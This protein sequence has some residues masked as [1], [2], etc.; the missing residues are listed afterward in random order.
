MKADDKHPD[1]TEVLLRIRAGDQKAF[2]EL[3]ELYA[4]LL[5]ATVSRYADGLSSFDRDDLH[6]G[7]CLALYRAALS[8]D[9]TRDEVKF[10][11]YAKVCIS[12]ALSTQVRAI[13]RRTFEIP[14]AEIRGGDAH[15]IAEDP[16]LRVLEEEALQA[17]RAR[18]CSVLSPFENRVWNLLMAG[19]PVR[20]IGRRLGKEPHSIE[21]AVYR[22]RQK[23]RVEFDKGD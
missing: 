3:L 4:P 1:V 2:S 14:V 10:G 23:L 5:S 19:F 22:I 11:L 15:E 12:N 21:N 17:L 9:L 18:I 16:A 13:H 8:Y 7:A 20:E 6:Q